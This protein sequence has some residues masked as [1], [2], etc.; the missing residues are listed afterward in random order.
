M[1][2]DKLTI[3]KVFQYL[4]LILGAVVALLP[5]LVVFIGSFKSNNELIVS[6]EGN[7]VRGSYELLDQNNSLLIT[8]QGL[9]EH[10]NFVNVQN[11]YFLINK[12]STKNIIMLSHNNIF[13]G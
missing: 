8:M 5:I 6:V 9:T 12:V 13:G 11:D 7:V 10:F 2:K 4:V 1:R 3:G